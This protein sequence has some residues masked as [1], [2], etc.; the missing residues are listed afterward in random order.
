MGQLEVEHGAEGEHEEA[1]ALPADGE[2]GGGA[3]SVRVEDGCPDGG[4]DDLANED[5]GVCQST[6]ACEDGERDVRK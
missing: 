4:S 2:G 5:L 6:E 3:P 1:E